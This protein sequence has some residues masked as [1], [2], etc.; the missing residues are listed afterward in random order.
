MAGRQVPDGLLL[1]AGSE[2]VNPLENVSKFL[3]HLNILLTF[4]VEESPD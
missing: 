1:V 3:N 2:I 4:R